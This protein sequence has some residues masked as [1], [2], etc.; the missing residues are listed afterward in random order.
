MAFKLFIQHMFSFTNLGWTEG[1][2]V[3]QCKNKQVIKDFYLTDLG[4]FA[5]TQICERTFNKY[6]MKT[7]SEEE[8]KSFCLEPMD[9]EAGLS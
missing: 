6:D 2:F 5:L 8:R 3:N 1:L 9:V 7:L 4:K